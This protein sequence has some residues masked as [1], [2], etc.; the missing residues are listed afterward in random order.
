MPVFTDENTEVQRGPRAIKLRGD[1]A[2][3]SLV[4]LSQHNNTSLNPCHDL[5]WHPV[6]LFYVGMMR[7]SKGKEFVGVTKLEGNSGLGPDYL[8]EEA[9]WER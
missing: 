3:S 1:G 7:F 5:K 9:E 4:R 2:S 8:G 6:S